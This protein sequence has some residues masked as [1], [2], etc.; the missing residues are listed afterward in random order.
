[1]WTNITPPAPGFSSTYGTAG[2]AINPSN[3]NIIYAC[4]DTLGLWKTPDRGTTWTRLGDYSNTYNNGTTSTYLDSPIA[5][6]VDPGNPNHIVA[7]DGVRG[8]T[9]GFWVSQDGGNTWTMPAAFATLAA[10]TTT[11]D[12][13]QMAVDPSNF[14]HIIVVSHSPWQGL[15]NAGIMETK[16]GGATWVTHAPVSSWSSGTLAVNFLYDIPSGQGN[17]NTWLVGDWLSDGMWRTADGGNSWTQVTTYSAAHAGGLIFYAS[18]GTIYSGSTPYP[19][20][21]TDNGLT[22]HQVNATGMPYSYYYAVVGDGTTLYTMQSS[23]IIGGY[24]TAP[25]VVTSESTGTTSAWSQY[26]GGTQTFNN[27]P[28]LMRYDAANGIMY[29]ANWGAGFWALKVIK[30]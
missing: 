9:L 22:W 13:T 30:P 4:I 28:F 23:P 2:F 24:T 20:Y 14:N 6:A 25:F 27:G 21:S 18:D 7:T 17:S 29:S 5:V 11:R 26:Q 10:S 16:D 19:I 8:Q 15:P 12:V 1:V 3:P